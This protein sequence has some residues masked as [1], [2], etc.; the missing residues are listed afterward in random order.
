MSLRTTSKRSLNTSRDGD[1]TIS[2]GSP[3]QCLT[4]LSEKKY[5]LIQPEFHLAQLEA[6]PYSPIAIYMGKEAESHLTTASLQVVVES[7]EVS[8]EPPLLQTK[9]SQ[10]TQLLHTRLVLQTPHQLHCPLDILQGL[11]DFLA[12]RGPKLNT[13]LKVQPHQ[14]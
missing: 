2:Q 11:N 10:L 3:F 1:S 13:V 14:G 6:V 4:T 5:F 7:D 8:P 9:Q 12:V